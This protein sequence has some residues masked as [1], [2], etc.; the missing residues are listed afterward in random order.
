LSAS[1]K[2][3]A[4]RRDAVAR[5]RAEIHTVLREQLAEARTVREMADILA[6]LNARLRTDVATLRHD[7][8]EAE[9]ASRANARIL[10]AASH[11]LRQPLYAM[12]LIIEALAH[13]DD[14]AGRDRALGSLASALDGMHDLVQ[15]LLEL[16][17]MESEGVAPRIRRFS[18]RRLLQRLDDRF[19]A[20]ARAEGVALRV[21]ASTARLASDPV[22]LERIVANLVANAFRHARAGKIVLGCR[23]RPAGVRIEV[24]D[25][26]VGIAE[27]RQREIFGEYVGATGDGR[28]FGLGLAIAERTARLLG[29]TIAVRSIPGRGTVFSVDIAAPPKRRRAAARKS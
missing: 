5:E 19:A 24:W 26:G 25:N 7:V 13:L 28:G 27:D 6:D 17:R 20:E 29:H 14:R 21:V 2:P 4:G 9:R 3:A 8:D 12:G 23:R 18:A 10:A 16:S 1:R 11:D 15:G 22:L